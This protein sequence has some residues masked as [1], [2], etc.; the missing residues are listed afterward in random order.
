MVSPFNVPCSFQGGHKQ[1]ITIYI[2]NPDKEH[3][4]LHFQADWLM[5]MRGGAISPDVMENF[6]KL[7]EIADQNGVSFEELCIYAI[8]ASSEAVADADTNAENE[9]DS[10]KNS[11]MELEGKKIAQ[12]IVNKT[13]LE[14]EEDSFQAQKFNNS[15]HES[16]IDPLSLD[17]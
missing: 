17:K 7:K 4:P 3:H 14:R 15:P 1:N 12:D 16:A 5:K 8:K 9:L 11:E 2:G 10:Q 6:R 13:A